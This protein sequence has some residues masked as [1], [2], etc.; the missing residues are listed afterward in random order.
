VISGKSETETLDADSEDG[1][2]EDPVTALRVLPGGP[3]F[4]LDALVRDGRP[5]RWITVGRDSDCDI[6][7]DEGTV[8]SF[9]CVLRRSGARVWIQDDKNKNHTEVNGVPLHGEGELR[10]GH[11]I[12]LGAVRLVACG[13]LGDAQKPDVPAPDIESLVDGA[14]P[15]YDSQGKA[16]SAVGMSASK[17]SRWITKGLVGDKARKRDEGDENEGSHG[18]GVRWHDLGGEALAPRDCEPDERGNARGVRGSR[19]ERKGRK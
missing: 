8:S 4:E 16:A 1:V 6:R 11:A 17:L 3:T 18:E 12:R 19:T 5:L 10:P 7:I 9:H 2:P 13:K 14:L 15:L